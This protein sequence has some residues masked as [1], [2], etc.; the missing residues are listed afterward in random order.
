M[1]KLVN[2]IR[3]LGKPRWKHIIV[4]FQF[5]AI[6]LKSLEHFMALNH[7][8]RALTLVHYGGLKKINA[9]FKDIWPKINFIQKY[10]TYWIK[11]LKIRSNNLR[12]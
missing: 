3:V 12:N 11:S 1:P 4:W 6:K 8:H 2:L 10:S 9:L 5:R 7:H